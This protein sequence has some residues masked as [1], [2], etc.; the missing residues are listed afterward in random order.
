MAS[1]NIVVIGGSSGSHAVLRRIIADLPADFPAAVLVVSHMPAH[2][3]GLLGAMLGT[4][5]ALPVHVAEE[6]MAV[7]RGNV[8]VAAPN[9]HLL[10]VDGLLRLGVGPR[11]NMS[12]PA[13]DPLFR[14]AAVQGGLT[15][16]VVLSGMLGDGASGLAAIKR[17]GGMTIVQDPEDAQAGE[18]PVAAIEASAPDFILP[19][20]EIA[21]QLDRLVRE[22][23]GSAGGAAPDDLRIEI[24]I[25]LG[26]RC[27]SDVIRAL[28][29]PVPITCPGCHGVLSE[30]ND[31]ASLRY[32]CQVGHGYTAD[33]LYTAQEE[34][35]DEALRVALRVVEER[36]ELVRRMERDARGAGRMAV[37]EMYGAR[38]AEYRGYAETIRRAVILGLNAAH[39]SGE[40]E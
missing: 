37:A 31:K 1:E 36:V 6:G 29:Q 39:P 27:D 40:V 33:A 35:V 26:G 19:A 23:A 14:S 7:A 5:A 30:M 21:A 13:I 3:P 4:H 16:G 15:I 12:R 11:E 17:M 28:A 32:R 8:Y 24:E 22:N 10:I 9:H 18:M 34:Q 20:A 25:A 38:G 2:A